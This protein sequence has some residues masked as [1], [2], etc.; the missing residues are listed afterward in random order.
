MK[1]NTFERRL[2][3]IKGIN[4]VVTCEMRVVNQAVRVA[5]AIA[6]AKKAKF[7]AEAHLM[8]YEVA[9]VIMD[10]AEHESVELINDFRDKRD[11]NNAFTLSYGLVAD[12]VYVDFSFTLRKQADDVVVH[13]INVKARK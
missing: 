11:I 1:I 6:L 8:V 3:E 7:N 5:S 12:P 2:G 9:G 4:R 10:I 13:S